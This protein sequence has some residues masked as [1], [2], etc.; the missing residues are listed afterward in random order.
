MFPEMSKQKHLKMQYGGDTFSKQI[1][2]QT[3]NVNTQSPLF[4]GE[5]YDA[6]AGIRKLEKPMLVFK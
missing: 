4:L 6:L 1:S 5:T 2:P 3:E